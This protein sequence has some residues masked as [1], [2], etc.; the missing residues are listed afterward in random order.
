MKIIF[1]L[2]GTIICSKKRV[3]ELFSDLIGSRQ[4]SF[5]DYWDLK[6]SRKSNQ[7]ILKN[8]FNYSDNKIEYF[9][10]NWMDLIEDDRYLEMDTLI[11]GVK[12][13]LVGISKNN[14][15]YICTARQSIQQVE[16]QLNR[17]DIYHFFQDVLVTE[18]KYSKKDLLF[19]KKLM[20]D[21]QDWIVGDTGHDIITG[22]ELGIKTCAV[23]SGFMS[24]D[25][26]VSYCPDILIQ[27]VTSFKFS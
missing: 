12:E 15:L 24:Q 3:H 25:A 14:E 22:K 7:D 19:N 21:K 5:S 23:L 26:L 16:K 27:D 17:L 2:D 4:L 10:N 20:L 8:K 6:F 1:D 11:D 18:Q 9:L 13:F